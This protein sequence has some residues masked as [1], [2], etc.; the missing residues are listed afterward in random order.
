MPEAEERRERSRT[1]VEVDLPSRG[2]IGVLTLS[3]SS[4][5]SALCN[6]APLMGSVEDGYSEHVSEIRKVN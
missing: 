4:S 5:S 2:V 6:S 3:D 1:D